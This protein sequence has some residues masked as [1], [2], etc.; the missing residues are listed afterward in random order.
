VQFLT[1][2]FLPFFAK[3][4]IIA[5]YGKITS[6]KTGDMKHEED[7]ESLDRIGYRREHVHKLIQYPPTK[8]LELSYDD[9]CIISRYLSANRSFNQSFDR[10]LRQILSVLNEQAVQV[11]TKSLKCLTEIVTVDPNILSQ[12][13]I[14]KSIRSRMEDTATSVREA[15]IDLIG[16][17]VLTRP[18]V[19][20]HYYKMLTDRILDTGVSV[21]KRV[22]KILRDLCLEV[23]DFPF[24]ANACVRMIKRVNDDE[25][26]IK[27]LV[28]EVFSKLWFTPVDQDHREFNTKV[29]AKVTVVIDVVANCPDVEWLQE[30]FKISKK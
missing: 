14:A 16:K 21:R 28:L 24:T 26:G 23:E 2:R 30:R 11:R 8:G 17:F 25:E 27:K 18:E 12:D 7:A 19:A 10:Y 1:F 22:I 5:V 6:V 9:I 3:L 29:N 15:A 20:N 13:A 4:K